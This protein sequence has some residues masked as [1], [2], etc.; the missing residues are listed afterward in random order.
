MS[1]DGK[2]FIKGIHRGKFL[3]TV[4]KDHFPY[5]ETRLGKDYAQEVVRLLDERSQPG[6]ESEPDYVLSKVNK[7]IF[8]SAS[9][10]S[11]I[12]VGQFH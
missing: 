4:A 12:A 8:L 7:Q 11:Y 10:D 9:A 2:F 5:L 6:K 3:T 1:K